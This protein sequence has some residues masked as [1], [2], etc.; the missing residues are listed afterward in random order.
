MVRDRA[1]WSRKARAARE[2]Q[3]VIRKDGETY[4]LYPL[5]DVVGALGRKWSLLIVGIL[6]N[7]PRTRFHE[8]RAA[9]PG[10][11]P[12]TL[13]DRLRELEQLGLVAREAFA[14]VPLRVEYTLTR[15]GTALRDALVPLLAW[16]AGRA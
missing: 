9:L 6:G 1:A 16:A 7:R 11:S 12:R 14:E 2:D 8:V 13:T 5:D 15:D 4:C 3:C 10:L